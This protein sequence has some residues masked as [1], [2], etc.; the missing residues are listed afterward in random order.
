MTV[1]MRVMYAVDTNGSYFLTTLFP[2][3][4]YTAQ[5]SAQMTENAPPTSISQSV[6]NE[7]VPSVITKYEPM[8][9]TARPAF[10]PGDT[11]S[12]SLT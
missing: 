9:D 1:P 7:V 11:R 6:M 8:A 10:C 2:S 3:T 12:P 4:V 5:K